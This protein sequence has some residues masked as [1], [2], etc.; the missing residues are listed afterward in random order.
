M[1][2]HLIEYKPFFLLISK[3]RGS[4]VSLDELAVS[5]FS[6]CDKEK[7]LWGISVLLAIAPLARNAKGIVLFPS[8]YAYAF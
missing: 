8:S 7:A 3:C 2:D 1:Y 4:A 5:V 6:Q